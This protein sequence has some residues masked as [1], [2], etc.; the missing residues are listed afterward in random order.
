MGGGVFVGLMLVLYFT[1]AQDGQDADGLFPVVFNLASRARI[2]VNATCGDDGPEEFCKLVE[3]VK[4]FSS[5]NGHCDI[6]DSRSHNR[7]RNHP[8]QNAIDGSNKRWQSPTLTR[9]REYNYVTITL[10]LGQVYQVA[11]VII[12]AANAPR[13][14]NWILERSIDGSTYTPWQYFA[15]SKADCRH[16]YGIEP[17][18]GIPTSLRDDEV[19]C[20]TRYSRLNPLENGEIFVSLVNGRPGVSQPSP[21]LLEFTSAKYIRLRLQKIRTL[22]ADL[23]TLQR[24]NY[25][26]IDPSVTRRYF[27]SLKDI[28]VGGLCICYGHAMWCQRHSSLPDR[29]QCQCQHNTCGDNC[30][31]CCPG[32]HQQVWQRGRNGKTIECEKCNCHNKADDCVYNATIAALGLSLN[33]QGQYS[34]GGVCL[35]CREFTTGINCEKCV[36]GYYR[37]R[38]M[39][40][41]SSY[42]CRPCNCQETRTSTSQCV[43]D[44]SFIH[45]G[46]NPGDCVCKPGFGGPQCSQCAFGYYGYP[47]CR[48]CLCNPAGSVNPED[49]GRSCI[50]KNHVEGRKCDHCKPGYYHLDR[51]N[52]DGCTQCFCF[53]VSSV[54]DSADWALV[55]VTD[56]TGWTISTLENGGI[57]LLPQKRDGWLMAKIFLLNNN[58]PRLESSGWSQQADI[59]YWV[60]SMMFLGN[61]LSSYGGTLSYVMKYTIDDDIDIRYHLSEPDVIIEGN[62]IK[63]SNGRQFLRE[64]MEN[65]VSVRL[66]ES[67]WK[68]L[69]RDNQQEEPISKKQF[70][71]VLQN[72]NRL[73]IRASYH[74]AQDSVFLKDVSLEMASPL[75]LSNITMLTVEQCQCPDGFA[76]LSCESC[77]PGYR[78]L[79]DVLYKGVCQSCNCHRHAETCDSLTGKCLNCL[80]NTMGDRCDRCIP[81]FYGDPRRGLSTDCKPCA[82]PHPNSQANLIGGCVHKAT[83][84]DSEDYECLKCPV[85]QTGRHC[86]ICMPGYYGKPDKLGGRCQ[87]CQCSGNINL[88]VPGACDPVTGKCLRCSENTE[89]EFCEKC[90]SGYFGSALQ[91]NCRAC[92]CYGGGSY[93]KDCDPQTG[94]CSCKPLYAGRQ[95]NKCQPGYGNIQ[96]GCPRCHCDRTGSRDLNCDPVTGQ[97]S[98]RRG[99][100]G[101][102]CDECRDGFYG[103]SGM[104][105][106]E[107]ECYGPGTSRTNL[108]D[109]QTGQCNCR[110]NVVGH[111]CDRCQVGYWGIESRTGCVACSCHNVGSTSPQCDV[112]TGQ[113]PCRVNVGSQQCDRCLPGYYGMSYG[114]CR[115]C[116]PCNEPG[117]ICDQKTG[118][119]VCPPNTRGPRCEECIDTAWNYTS[120]G[121]KVNVKGPSCSECR[122]NSFSL[123]PENPKGCTECYCYKRSRDCFQARYV[124]HTMTIPIQRVAIG[125][126]STISA[127]YKHIYQ[128]IPTGARRVSVVATSAKQPLYWDLPNTTHGD[129]TLSYNGQLDFL[130]YFEGEDFAGLSSQ[131]RKLPLVLLIGNGFIIAYG[132]NISLESKHPQAL[133]VKLHEGFWRIPGRT[134]PIS[135]G[136]MMVVLQNVQSIL[137][138]ATNTG[139]ATYAELGPISLQVAE[140]L[141]PNGT[142]DVAMGIEQCVCPPRYSGLSCQNPAPGYYRERRN[143]TTDITTPERAIGGVRP[144]QCYDHSSDCHSETGICQNCQHNTTGVHCEQCLPGYFGVATRGSPWDC[145]PCQCPRTEPSNNFSPTCVDMRGVLVCTNCSEG[146]AGRRCERCAPGYWGNPLE[147]GNTCKPCDCNKE[148]STDENCD[149]HTGRC[150]CLPGIQGLKC[151]ACGPGHA[152]LNGSCISCYDGCT[153]ILLEDLTNMNASVINLNITAPLPWR[154]LRYL[155]NQT[156]ELWERMNSSKGAR[157]GDL[158]D[159]RNETNFL[160]EV[161]ERLIKRSEETTALV[162]VLDRNATV[163]FKNSTDLEDEIVKLFADIKDDTEK[164]ESLVEKLFYNQSG[165]NITAAFQEAKHILDEIL[166]RDFSPIDAEIYNENRLAEKLSERIQ[167]LWM[168]NLNT[169]GVIAKLADAQKRL[170]DLHDLAK[171]AK[172]KSE[173]VISE[174]VLKYGAKLAIVEDLLAEISTIKEDTSELLKD[175][176]YYISEARDLLDRLLE[177]LLT[178]GREYSTLEA[179]TDRLM[180]IFNDMQRKLP[181]SKQLTKDAWRHARELQKYAQDLDALFVKTRADAEAPIKAAKVYQ[182]IVD[183]INQAEKAAKNALKTSKESVKIAMIETLK[184]EVAN[185]ISRSRELM[186]KANHTMEQGVGGLS[187]DLVFLEGDLNAVMMQQTDSR[188]MLNMINADLDRLPTDLSS[189]IDHVLNRVYLVSERASN[190]SLGVESIID[191]VHDLQPKIEDIKRFDLDSMIYQIRDSTNKA[192]DNMELLKNI[193][194]ELD[195]DHKLAQAYRLQSGLTRNLAELKERIKVSR[196]LAN[197]MK[198]SLKGDGKCARSYRPVS[199]PSV[200]NMISF[201]FKLNKSQDNML[202]ILAQKSPKEYLAVELRNNQVRFTWNVG[203]GM[204]EIVHDQE[205]KV[206]LPDDP[207]GLKW[208]RVIAKRIARIG[209]LKVWPII[210]S[211]STAKEQSGTSPVGYSVMKFDENSDLFFG[212]V[213]ADYS[214]PPSVSSKNLTGCMGAVVIDG[215]G[216]GTFHF[217]ESAPSCKACSDVPRVPVSS[218]EYH[219]DGKGYSKMPRASRFRSERI[220]IAF[221][222]K[223]YWENALFYFSGNPE[224]G[225]FISV[226]LREGKVVFQFYTGGVSLGRGE[227]KNTYNTNKWVKVQID[228]RNYKALLKVDNV[229]SVL[230]EAPPGNKDLNLKSNPMYFGGI[231]DSLDLTPYKR[232]TDIERTNFLGCMRSVGV[233]GFSSTLQDLFSGNYVGMTPGCKDTG[234]RKAGFY[235]DGFTT[236]KGENM[237]KN[238]GDVSLSFVTKQSDALLLLA[239]SVDQSNYYSLSLVDGHI[240]GHFSAGGKPV[241]L[242]APGKWNDGKVHNIAVVKINK[243]LEMLV[244]DRKMAHGQLYRAIDLK[245]NG[246]MYVGGVPRGL[247]ISSMVASDQPLKG[248]VSDIVINGKLLNMNLPVQYERADIGRCV[249]NINGAGEFNGTSPLLPFPII[250]GTSFPLKAA[251]TTSLYFTTT[252]TTPATTTARATTARPIRVTEATTTPT[253]TSP[254]RV[255]KKVTTELTGGGTEGPSTCIMSNPDVKE[256]NAMTFGNSDSSYAEIKIKKKEVSKNFS[257]TFQFRTFYPNG[258]FFLLTNYEQSDFFAAQLKNGNVEVTFDNQGFQQTIVSSGNYADGLWHSVSVNKGSKN[259]H[260]S[261]ENQKRLR[262]KIKRR[263]NVATPMYVGGVPDPETLKADLVTHSV[264]G[265]IRNFFINKEYIDFA[266]IRTVRGVFLCSK[267]VEP[268]AGFAGISWGIFAHQF[269]VGENLKVSLEF[270]TSKQ[271]GIILTVSSDGGQV[272]MTLELYNGRVQ[273]SLKNEEGVQ[274]FTAR[275]SNQNLYVACDKTW[276][277]VKAQ[278]LRNVISVQLDNMSEVFVPSPGNVRKTKTNSPLFIG[279]Y[280]SSFAPQGAASS[281]VGFEGCMR[282]LSINGTVVDWY[283]LVD[284]SAIQRT[285]CPSF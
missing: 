262:A 269:E 2:S 59:H 284:I 137:V 4:I 222:F 125:P 282:N 76:G 251:S 213:N 191:K 207:E 14:G 140:P 170:Q 139:H 279:G 65:K 138:R 38:G 226:E 225:D 155:H 25:K 17:T 252:T 165:V 97:C 84:A 199:Q 79:N 172:E 122:R 193:T 169:S 234:I 221:E 271:N 263:L 24:T 210:I 272:G 194:A 186:R 5:Q 257:I 168:M 126:V 285:A 110:P 102:H 9:G 12:K 60:A 167:K 77:A 34:G 46:L 8:I 62:G 55:H 241:I 92:E 71:M 47:N 57:T 22:N 53:G 117:H 250:P 174:E 64:T 39:T 6:C 90:S 197:N 176:T 63:I 242:T 224:M 154:P 256:K 132:H 177:N 121:C 135:R 218:N 249:Y 120:E 157:S 16:V 18:I 87:P 93:S 31:L 112:N 105:C 190:V 128:V 124:W 209:L 78:R 149:V 68:K 66:H 146:Y 195:A 113:C 160:Q 11:Y 283:Q 183:A 260:L 145:A 248:C 246:Q 259:I 95:C 37:P 175:G 44:D 182:N 13:P 91:G 223:T 127:I 29:M 30:E 230:I 267:D 247:D 123:D 204:G 131:D 19:I 156:I 181:R 148:G 233:G 99:I 237:P 54:C 7:Y 33:I 119:C 219:F 185:S 20:T 214:V 220:N 206:A 179:V 244:D 136:L 88:Q 107:C 100:G 50:C 98:C 236:F 270:R 80:H 203:G 228:R 89:G 189:K 111:K 130:H 21:V 114:G 1:H 32:Y 235:G 253:T 161:A 94:Q 51:N 43:L 240:E 196:E 275:S 73:L 229:E 28:S 42:P 40:P 217:K 103:H 67:A 281:N 143:D 141:S 35:N 215:N 81:G 216:V 178:I 166:G 26:D 200:T 10:D 144:C 151:D 198:L 58:S 52:P 164:L 276:H 153:G 147:V 208:Y 41:S 266:D 96:D 69:G 116:E 202:F 261:V 277:T 115:R 152:V 82:C 268:G 258:M 265:C 280:P 74:T 142:G 83:P 75:S 264:R 255:P 61:R 205:I 134:S 274:P 108:C 173:Q 72:I 162:D 118:K 101:L 45:K 171:T 56:L 184:N 85:G 239:N 273:F 231:P 109:Q 227:T 254:T 70:M 133:S 243:K 201:G 192:R 104:G 3:H 86:E 150:D 49:C 163:L 187:A 278:V 158:A 129:M 212:G 238:S 245:Q 211:E 180:A 188:N 15:M 232:L 106:R 48:L 23:M 27:Y 159:F 36:E